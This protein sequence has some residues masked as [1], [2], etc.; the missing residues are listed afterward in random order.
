M[1]TDTSPNGTVSLVIAITGH[2]D[3]FPE[4]EKQFEAAIQQILL[5]EKKKYPSTSLL[6]LSGLAEGADRIA[7]R[8]AVGLEIPYVAVLPMAPEFYRD[9][10]NSAQSNTEFEEMLQ[11]AARVIEIPCSARLGLSHGATRDHQYDC[12]GKFLVSASQIMIA[13]WDQVR[14]SKPGGTSE[15]VALKLA[16]GRQNGRRGFAGPGS[17]GMGPV[18]ILLARRQSTGSEV[19][20]GPKHEIRYPDGTS[21]DDFE[22]SYRLIDQY[23]A[24]VRAAGNLTREVATSRQNICG[25]QET[26]GLTP[27]MEWTATVYS[28]A[29]TLAI[30][31]AAR[32]L[33]LWK[34]VYILLAIAGV[35]LTFLHATESRTD[36]RLHIMYYLA[37]ALAFSLGYWEI[38]DQHRQRHEE[39]RALAEA[40]RVQFFWLAAGLRDMAYENFLGKQAGKTI[41]IR[42]AMSEISLYNDVASTQTRNGVVGEA[43]RLSLARTWVEGQTGYFNKACRKHQKRHRLFNDV[44][45]V[46]VG[47]G[48]FLPLIGWLTPTFASQEIPHLK[49]LAS[50]VPTIAM[51]WAALAWNYAELRGYVQ[52]ARQY[53]RMHDLF[54]A[55]KSQLQNLE[56]AA[57]PESFVAAQTTIRELGQDALEENGD[58]LSMHRE[59]KLKPGIIAG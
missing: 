11:N 59:R 31:Y 44:A 10:F 14:T 54:Y 41:W 56:R 13:V 50:I 53:A 2:R 37:L 52:E 39:Y 8:A 1:P 42:D 55:A 51:L 9:D 34:S 23:N 12:L 29:D 58:W 46:L 26:S 35:A 19:P 27:A 30:H 48:F 17:S 15:V 18:H 57:K 5:K 28:W 32:S 6:L 25:G 16:E 45:L 47:V 4:D 3:L 20:T 49:Q 24:D 21:A 38:R 40:L 36:W 43:A 22:A 33:R 7:V